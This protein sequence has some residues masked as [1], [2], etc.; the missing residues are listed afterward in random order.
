MD[1]EA[2]VVR[3]QTYDVTFHCRNDFLLQ[4][5]NQARCFQ[6][7]SW[8]REIP[9][10]VEQCINLVN[11]IEN[12]HASKKRPSLILKIIECSLK[13]QSINFGQKCNLTRSYTFVTFSDIIIIH[14][15]RVRHTR[16][17][18]KNGK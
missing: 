11:I 3:K 8:S 13:H 1:L 12:I 7:G 9:R 10:C 5:P 6:N 2:K 4:G 15:M 17:N 14:Q 16:L 18:T